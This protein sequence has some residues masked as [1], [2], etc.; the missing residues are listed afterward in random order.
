MTQVIF[1]HDPGQRFGRKDFSFLGSPTLEPFARIRASVAPRSWP[2]F[3]L[4]AIGHEE[5]D[6]VGMFGADY[7]AYRTRAGK[8][9]P[10]LGRRG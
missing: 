4:I 8:L 7:E 6:L 2:R 1:G 3:T 9:V 10:K 5:R